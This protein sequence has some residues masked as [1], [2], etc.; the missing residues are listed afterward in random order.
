MSAIL[1]WSQCVKPHLFWR[2]YVIAVDK[3]YQLRCS[4]YL[5]EVNGSCVG[6]RHVSWDKFSFRNCNYT[7]RG[8]TRKITDY[9]W[10]V[11]IRSYYQLLSKKSQ[12]IVW[13]IVNTRNVQLLQPLQHSVDNKSTFPFMWNEFQLSTEHTNNDD[14]WW[15]WWMMMR[16]WWWCD[17][18]HPH[19]PPTPPPSPHPPT[20]P[21]PFSWFREFARHWKNI[22]FVAK[23]GTSMVYALVASGRG[24]CDDDGDKE[25]EKDDGEEEEGEE[26]GIMIMIVVAVLQKSGQHEFRDV[27]FFVI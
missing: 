27:L 12:P 10:K 21:H 4:G 8:E 23:M 9:T 6:A 26:D 19:L 24:G 15:W 20:P 25:E 22:P 7:T 1:I 11:V 5:H 3:S 16:W 17:A 18:P 2:I 14:E 13:Y